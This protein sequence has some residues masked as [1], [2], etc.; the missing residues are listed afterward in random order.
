MPDTVEVSLALRNF[1]DDPG[2]WSWFFDTVYAAEQAGFDRV[3]V[4]DHVIMGEHLDDYAD[5]AAGGWE[6]KKQPTGPDGHYLEPLTLLAYLAA[7]TTR[8]RLGT[9]IV[10]APLRNP[11]VLAKI[12]A[13]VDVLSAGRLDLGVGVGWQADEYRAVGVPFES[14]GKRLD[15]CLEVCQL[16]WREQVATYSGETVSFERIHQMPK[17]VQPAGVPIWVSGRVNKPVMRRLAR[18]GAGW[19]PW[20]AS[21]TELPAQI[22][23]MRE[24]VAEHGRNPDDIGVV[25]SLGYQPFRD[26]NE[27]HDAAAALV[28]AG[29]TDLRVPARVPPG[30]EA[31]VDYLR[32]LRGQV[33][34]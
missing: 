34:V 27:M 19:I 11:V 28:E 21:A 25:G 29:A 24:A 33:A 18:F 3:L 2:D 23:R 32:E 4:S 26:P 14:R 16:L 5:P 31:A 8:I 30:R 15:E 10:L 6:G 22:R 13:T 17:P 9:N 1:D 12:A 7:Q 20:G